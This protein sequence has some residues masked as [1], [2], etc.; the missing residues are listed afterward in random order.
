MKLS[1]RASGKCAGEKA[2]AATAASYITKLLT[3][4]GRTSVRALFRAMLPR[5]CAIIWISRPRRWRD[6]SRPTGTPLCKALNSSI[7]KPGTLSSP[8][9]V[10]PIMCG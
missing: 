9:Q 10:R 3:V 1:S 7:G 5:L 4:P 6:S 2:S 8:G